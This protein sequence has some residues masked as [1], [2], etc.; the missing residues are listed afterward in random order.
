MEAGTVTVTAE[1]KQHDT[2]GAD[3]G[4]GRKDGGKGSSADGGKPG[5]PVP[6]RKRSRNLSED[7]RF[8]LFSGTANPELARKI[9]EHIGVK[10][11]ETKLQRFADGEVFFQLLENV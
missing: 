5:A 3:S 8:R 2:T 7:K 1:D 9:G 10:V 11:G 6:E 4:G